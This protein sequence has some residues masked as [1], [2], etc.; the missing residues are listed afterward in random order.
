MK[1]KIVRWISEIDPRF[2][3]M[4]LLVKTLLLATGCYSRQGKA[5]QIPYDIQS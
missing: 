4:I 5:R 2:R 3:D 1:C